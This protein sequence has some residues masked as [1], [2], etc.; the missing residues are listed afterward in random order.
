[1]ATGRATAPLNVRT[2]PGLT[3][4][5]IKGLFTDT[6]L[7]ILAQDGDW[8]QIR[9]GELTGYVFAEYVEPDKS[10]PMAEPTQPPTQ[11]GRAKTS[12]NLR[13]GPSTNHEVITI[14]ETNAPLALISQQGD[15]LQVLA[16]GQQK[17][18]T[19][20]DFV[21]RG[22]EGVPLGF[23]SSVGQSDLTSLPLEPSADQQ[24]ITGPESTSQQR[25]A[26][27]TWNRYGGLLIPLAE[28][29]NIDPKVA[30]AVLTIESSG[31]SFGSDGR[32][33]IRFENHIFYEKWGKENENWFDQHFR[34]D[35]SRSWQGHKWRKPSAGDDDWQSFHD[36]QTSEWELFEFACSLDDT[37]AKLSISM[38]AP[39][40]MG[41]NHTLLG[42]EAVQHMF[43][44]F[45][46]SAHHQIIG[47]FDFVQGP[48]T[49]SRRMLAL[50]NLDFNSFAAM[51]NGPGQAAFYGGRIRN[52]YEALQKI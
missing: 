1:M 12:L 23:L 35:W 43:T 2:G 38:G 22:S 33:I 28:R 29:L 30:A 47:F 4:D 51:Y 5:I 48:G 20:R 24:A 45:S 39:Q 34:F 31:N 11:V 50:Q 9:A 18:F 37:A 40:I 10:E 25:M 44:A 19:H 16:S 15:W 17:G 6:V 8:L 27:K 46:A 52:I 14:L 21:I 36:K 7:D 32:M 49:H 26:A 41:F 13:A 42:F 3:Y